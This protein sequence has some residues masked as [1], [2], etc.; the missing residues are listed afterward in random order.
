[1]NE[2][3][4]CLFCRHFYPHIGGNETQTMRLALELIK[5]G[6]EVMVVTS[7]VNASYKKYE[8][9]NGIKIHRVN[10]SFIF[11]IAQRIKSVFCRKRMFSGFIDENTAK[12]RK[13]FYTKITILFSLLEEYSFMWNSLR[14]L[15]LHRCEYDLIHSQILLNNGYIALLAGLKYNKPVLIK[16]ASLGGLEKVWLKPNVEKKKEKLRKYAYFVA[17]STQIAE[18]LEEQGVCRSHIFNIPNGI[19]IVKNIEKKHSSKA[20]IALFVG[21]FWQGKIKGLD[22]LLKAMGIV[23]Q[24]H[25]HVKLLIAGKGDIELYKQLAVI[26]KCDSN[27]EFLGQV[28]NVEELYQKST[29]FVLPSRQEGM[30][31]ATLEAMSYSMPCV[32]TNVSGSLD[33]IENGKEGIIVPIGNHLEMAKALCYMFDHP[34]IARKMG[35]AANVKVR[36]K[37]DISVVANDLINVY[38]TL[39]C[40]L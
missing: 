2:M 22:V 3:K 5:N 32:V 40:N 15:R 8:E 19:N 16:D 23:V 14:V 6:V 4:I 34:D 31:N 18:K 9:H 24:T 10:G 13:R 1:M 37:F 7:R 20:D 38:K 35:E 39:I 36:N 25:P 11:S 26:Y 30:S 21:N 33:Q 12:V 27:V 28:H 17:V 29:V